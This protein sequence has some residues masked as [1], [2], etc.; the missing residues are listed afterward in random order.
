VIEK[1]NSVPVIVKSKNLQMAAVFKLNELGAGIQLLL[2]AVPKEFENKTKEIIVGPT[3]S[4]KDALLF[5]EKHEKSVKNAIV[6]RSSDYDEKRKK[7]FA[8]KKQKK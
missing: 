7:A 1:M 6:A 4:A 5:N 3:S 2:A 8:N